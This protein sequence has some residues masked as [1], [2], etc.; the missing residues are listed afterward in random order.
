MVAFWWRVQMLASSEKRDVSAH[1]AKTSR[2]QVCLQKREPMKLLTSQAQNI[3]RVVG[4]SSLLCAVI[5]A[6]CARSCSKQY[7]VMN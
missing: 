7:K 3:V 5:A 6:F 4:L 2:R 1:A